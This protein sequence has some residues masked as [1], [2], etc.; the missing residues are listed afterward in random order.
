[1]NTPSNPH[2]SHIERAPYELGHLLKKMPRGLSRFSPLTGDDR[3]IAEAAIQHADN[4]NSTLLHGLEALGH[5]LATA[6]SNEEGEV[7]AGTMMR[8]GALVAH[9]A[10]ETQFVQELGATLREAIV[11]E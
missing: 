2:F 6:A 9:L 4:A 7:T 1:M 10:V 11:G 8:L 5:V 3:L